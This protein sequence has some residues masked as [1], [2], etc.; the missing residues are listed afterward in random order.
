MRIFAVQERIQLPQTSILWGQ[1]SAL[2]TT[3]APR[4][5]PLLW[6]GSHRGENNRTKPRDTD[7]TVAGI[8][9]TF[10]EFSSREL[11]YSPS[12]QILISTPGGEEETMPQVG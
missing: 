3:A 4:P 7:F 1:F 2:A 9:K 11:A 6:D 10:E 5:I 12:I 8:K